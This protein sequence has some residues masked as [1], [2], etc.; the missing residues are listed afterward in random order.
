MDS[1]G[2][3]FNGQ[4]ELVNN[5]KELYNSINNCIDKIVLS[6]LHQDVK[7]EERAIFQAETLLCQVQ[8]YLSNIIDYLP[9]ET[10][11]KI[12]DKVWTK[13]GGEAILC[14]IDDVLIVEDD[15]IL[16][17]VYSVSDLNER[18]FGTRFTNELFST[19]E[20]LLKSL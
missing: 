4:V 2:L 8:Q 14:K 11:Y 20:E 7:A 18:M 19:K 3:K 10:K 6:R 1:A 12:E 15:G 17:V 9:I 5:A 13:F 16:K